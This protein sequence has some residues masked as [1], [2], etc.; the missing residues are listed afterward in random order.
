MLHARAH[1]RTHTHTRTH[2]RT[3]V[4]EHVHAHTHTH[5]H[6]HAQYVKA[7]CSGDADQSISNHHLLGAALQVCTH[8][9]P[10]VEHARTCAMA[11]AEVKKPC[12]L[13]MEKDA[14]AGSSSAAA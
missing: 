12:V 9:A 14:N 6:T 7:R 8:I 10:V 5:T 11:Q 3:H 1:T 13:I 4:H 2:A